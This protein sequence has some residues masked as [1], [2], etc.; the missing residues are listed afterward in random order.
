MTQPSGLLRWA[1]GLTDVGFILYWSVTGLAAAGLLQ[2]PPEWLYKDYADPAM[3]VWNWS[4]APLDLLASLT[5]LAALWRARSGRRW[6]SLALVSATLTFCAGFMAISYWAIAGDLDPA[7]WAANLFLMA[8]PL[9][10][11]REL[12]RH[13][14][15]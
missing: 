3:V 6:A 13:L 11:A 4:F 5:G 7:W 14:S 10:C 15:D 8:W 12:F 9:A 1:M 2:I